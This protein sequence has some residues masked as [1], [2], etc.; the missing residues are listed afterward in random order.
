MCEC[1][2]N[3][4]V[5]QLSVYIYSHFLRF[6]S[7]GQLG[8]VLT[9]CFVLFD[10]CKYYSILTCNF[11]PSELAPQTPNFLKDISK[12]FLKTRWGRDVP[13]SVIS[14]CTILWLVNGGM[15]SLGDVTGVNIISPW[16]PGGLRV[17]AHGYQEVNIF[18]LVGVSTSVKQFRKVASDIN[19]II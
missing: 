8:T 14:S 7:K 16:A 10:L 18:Y 15:M 1:L 5:C 6:P 2:P 19:T 4:K 12:A 9:Q 3:S 17:C 13:E 11:T